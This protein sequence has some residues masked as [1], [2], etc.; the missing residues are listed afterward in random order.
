VAS[1]IEALV[2]ERTAKRRATAVERAGRL[3]DTL[4]ENGI[5]AVVIGSLATGRFRSHSDLD[6][7]VR[8]QLDPAARAFVERSTAA[9]MRDTGIPYDLIFGGDL[10]PRQ[11]DELAHD[12]LD[13]SGLRQARSQA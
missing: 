1:R 9:A 6:I 7:L 10:T 12:H 3:L 4:A 8:G 13:A 11:S 5:D 2:Q